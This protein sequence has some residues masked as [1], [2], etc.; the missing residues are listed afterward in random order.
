MNKFLV[1]LFPLLA[2]I[3]ALGACSSA[4]EDFGDTDEQAIY[5]IG[6]RS[7]QV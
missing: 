5:D 3:L 2:L 7:V 6:V 4:E 1:R